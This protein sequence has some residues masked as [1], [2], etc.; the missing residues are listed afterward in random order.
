MVEPE[1]RRS[2]SRC[3]F[4]VLGGT[5]LAVALSSVRYFGGT[6]PELHQRSVDHPGS[7]WNQTQTERN[8]LFGFSDRKQ[9]D[10]GFT[11]TRSFRLPPAAPSAAPDSQSP[12]WTPT[13]TTGPS[14]F[15]SNSETDSETPVPSPGP[16]NSPSATYV[17]SP[18]PSQ[19]PTITQQPR[20]TGPSDDPS[21]SYPGV[22]LLEAPT[23]TPTSRR[24][25]RPSPVPSTSSSPSVVPTSLPTQVSTD[26][27]TITPT[28]KP[29]EEVSH[30]EPSFEQSTLVPSIQQSST[31]PTLEQS[32]EGPTMEQTTEEPSVE[33]STVE[34]TLEPT[35]EENLYPTVMPNEQSEPGE[36]AYSSPTVCTGN[37]TVVLEH[38]YVYF[39]EFNTS[40]ASDGLLEQSFR[41][42]YQ[43]GS[44][45][46]E[47]GPTL[48]TVKRVPDP[49]VQ[50]EAT[51][52]VEKKQPKQYSYGQLLVLTERIEFRTTSLQYDDDMSGL[53]PTPVMQ[54]VFIGGLNQFFGMRQLPIYAI[55]LKE[56]PVP[57]PTEMPTVSMVPS[58]AAAHFEAP[59]LFPTVTV[60]PDETEEPTPRP[61]VTM[62]P[63][64]TE[65]PTFDESSAYSPSPEPTVHPTYRPSPSPTFLPTARVSA[66]IQFV[67]RDRPTSTTSP[68]P[69]ASGVPT[70]FSSVEPTDASTPIPSTDPT[71]AISHLPS[72]KPSGS[73][74]AN[75]T[76]A[77][78]ANPTKGPSAF[79]SSGPSVLPTEKPSS[80]PSRISHVPTLTQSVN[81]ADLPSSA[82]FPPYAK[83]VAPTTAN[84]S[85][86]P[87]SDSTGSP[88][89][90]L[91]F[92]PSTSPGS[93]A[94]VEP[95]ISANPSVSPTAS[96]TSRP[97]EL[98]SFRPL[99]PPD[100]TLREPELKSVQMILIGA[101]LLPSRSQ[102]VWA[103]TTETAIRE[104][105]IDVLN[106]QVESVDVRVE[107]VS[108]NPQQSTSRF[109]QEP[110]L[111]TPGTIS[112]NLTIIFDVE[113]YIRAVIE[114]HNVR[115]YVGAALDGAGDQSV[116]IQQLKS[117]GEAAFQDLTTVRLVLPPD[118]TGVSS[119]LT[120]DDRETLGTGM[121][122]G[123]AAVSIASIALLIVGVYMWA[124]RRPDYSHSSSSDQRLNNLND[125][126][127]SDL[128]FDIVDKPDVDVSTL[129]DPIP[130]GISASPTDV[131]IAE[132]T[133]S[134]PYDYKV[135]SHALPSL[136]E[137]G[138]FSYSDVGSNVMSVQ[139]DDDTLDAQYNIE[140]RIEVEAPPGMLGLV[141]E[142]DSEGVASVYDMKELSPL[143]HKIQIGD[144]LV[145][146]DDVD[147]SGMPV[148]L[149]MKLIAS[150]QKK[151]VRR[152]VF[153][154]PT[155]KNAH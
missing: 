104:E 118:K 131:S 152:M 68:F 96:P 67:P 150:K 112:S 142:E 46:M 24:T 98:P 39:E 81:H 41:E 145:S 88:S 17:P 114:D 109:L 33:Q 138:S 48:R 140:D 105:V 44:Y 95:S 134:L 58:E 106:N 54:G 71:P 40:I 146:V 49:E 3:A 25:P 70:V 123:I 15:P 117:S 53:F 141:L 135:A 113:F 29:T 14:L 56:A 86:V 35:L 137:S 111:D 144:K 43:N 149:V 55:G 19:S 37:Q 42:S 78:S 99:A 12:S 13:M 153:C 124:K 143:A 32:T 133:T 155:K 132:E 120:E 130:Q 136:D 100:F 84:T 51:T 93:G 75:P 23:E 89:A 79:P 139:T 82:S 6:G 94:T 27:S 91:S 38:F 57:S 11:R 30:M 122:V 76:G 31:E 60:L 62:F 9:E 147:V 126:D 77:P 125:D 16:S 65:A 8:L 87:S 129:G 90:N 61:T 18:V 28:L 72:V 110:A 10:P 26:T 5:M 148:Q 4:L 85:N 47:C 20:T 102:L 121:A 116:F 36:P 74:S 151:R 59:T 21:M 52:I 45:V 80:I 154:R 83:T 7:S 92:Q 69:S 115:R 107:I 128:A 2:L 34:P 50:E 22:P 66:P 101:S 119:S 63:D 97:S 64:E 103:E 127:V 1:P 108:Q 73:P